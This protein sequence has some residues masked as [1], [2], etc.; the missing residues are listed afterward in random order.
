[1]TPIDE[2]CEEVSSVK[3]EVVVH[4][5]KSFEQHVLTQNHVEE[6]SCVP[7]VCAFYVVHEL[8]L[9]GVVSVLLVGLR[10][11]HVNIGA[12][13]YYFTLVECLLHFGVGES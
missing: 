5:F 8:V 13:V 2:M 3:E 9:V 7:I 11:F 1:M 10:L 12:R 4:R 6:T